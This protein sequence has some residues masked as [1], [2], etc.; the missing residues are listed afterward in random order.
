MMNMRLL[1]QPAPAG[2]RDVD[3]LISWMLDTLDLIRRK[4]DEWSGEGVHTPLHRLLR[5]YF[6]EH[7]NQGW[8]VQAL[9]DE[10]GLSA[11]ALHHQISKLSECGLTGAVNREGWRV[12]HLRNGS[13]SN[14]VEMMAVE[15]RLV[16]NQRLRALNHWMKESKSRMD[17]PSEK[18]SDV[19][20]RIHIKARAP[21]TD[22]QDE[23][24]AF[25]QDLGLYGDRVRSGPDGGPP[26]G[27]AIFE[28]LLEAD[29][30]LSLDEALEKWGTTRPRL[31]RTLDR[32]CAAGLVERVPRNDRLPVTLWSAIVSQHGRRGSEWLVSKGGLGRID[33]RTS[34][35][36]VKAL[37][38]NSLNVEESEK[39]LAK[40][41]AKEQMIMLNLLGGRLPVGWRLTGENADAV[42]ERVLSRADRTFRRMKRVAESLEKIINT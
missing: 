14:A 17:I 20:L 6:L 42:R 41:P 36:I 33:T 37:D 1:E 32:F 30:P 5:D 34:N 4:G 13:L 22:G 27:R 2:S 21:L 9:G 26:L 28:H 19:P 39:I 29:S 3:Q 11:P 7:P 25:L 23:M 15:G 16:L 24:D 10:I 12:H 38:S 40:I 18:S 31:T 8:D 35:K